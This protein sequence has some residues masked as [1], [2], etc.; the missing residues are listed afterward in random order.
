VATV[1]EP[2]GEKSLGRRYFET[3]W[4][5]PGR[6]R[7][8]HAAFVAMFFRYGVGAVFAVATAVSRTPWLPWEASA[9]AWVGVIWF[10][11][12]LLWWHAMWGLHAMHPCARC[13]A[14]DDTEREVRARRGALKLFR[15]YHL[16]ADA[17]YWFYFQI[18]SVIAVSVT[19]DGVPWFWLL[20]VPL[21]VVLVGATWCTWFHTRFGYACPRCHGSEGPGHGT[22]T[23]GL[24]RKRRFS[25]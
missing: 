12:F 20:L 9:W 16:A 23:F 15:G 14:V 4:E 7:S 22:I 10:L 8:G 24:S 19:A 18:T 3:F 25:W 11:F 2:S 5:R 6:G 13:M 21:G 1:S 17:G